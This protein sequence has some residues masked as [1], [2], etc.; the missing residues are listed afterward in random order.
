M[1]THKHIIVGVHITDRVKHAGA[2]QKVFTEFGVHIKTRLGLHDVEDTTSSPSG[3]ILLELVGEE[4]K[5][6]SIINKLTAIRGV[7]AKK[8]VFSHD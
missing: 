8:M 2:V 1:K 5:C 3:I 6:S 4:K 7:D